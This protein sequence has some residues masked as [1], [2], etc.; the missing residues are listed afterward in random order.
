MSSMKYSTDTI[1]QQLYNSERTYHHMYECTVFRRNQ[2]NRYTSL[3][4]PTHKQ[5][6]QVL[7]P[8][9]FCLST[10]MLTKV[11]CITIIDKW[12]SPNNNCTLTNSCLI[13]LHYIVHPEQNILDVI[14]F[15]FSNFHFRKRQPILCFGNCKFPY[16]LTVLKKVMEEAND[17]NCC[18]D[19]VLV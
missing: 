10:I 14:R 13:M 5:Y 18:S 6:V 17:H 19:F 1:F 2:P 7:N 11:T 12:G 9:I 15:F 4:V 8:A 16:F 3:N